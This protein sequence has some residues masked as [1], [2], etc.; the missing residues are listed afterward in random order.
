MRGMQPERLTICANH[1]VFNIDRYSVSIRC[2]A[3]QILNPP[4]LF[5]G[6]LHVYYQQY[7]MGCFLKW[8]DSVS[9]HNGRC[10]CF[11]HSPQVKLITCFAASAWLLCRPSVKPLSPPKPLFKLRIRLILNKGTE[12]LFPIVSPLRAQPNKGQ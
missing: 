1:A 12:L 6:S 5:N 8:H 9:F 2:T 11:I 10:F 7:F 3:L 4:L